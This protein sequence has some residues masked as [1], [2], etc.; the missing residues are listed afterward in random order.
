MC[1]D[2]VDIEMREGWSAHPTLP[3]LT[4]LPRVVSQKAY[5]DKLDIVKCRINENSALFEHDLTSHSVKGMED[6]ARY[7]NYLWNGQFRYFHVA[8]WDDWS[9]S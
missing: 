1:A 2:E 6:K 5:G 3:K 7:A 8:A 9:G 4:I